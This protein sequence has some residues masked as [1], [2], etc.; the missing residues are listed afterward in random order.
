MGWNAG[1]PIPMGSS[2]SRKNSAQE[3]QASLWL[4][5]PSRTLGELA[6]QVLR[7]C[8]QRSRLARRHAA[9]LASAVLGGLGE[10]HDSGCV[11]DAESVALPIVAAGTDGPGPAKTSVAMAMARLVDEVAEHPDV[12]ASF[13]A[14]AGRRSAP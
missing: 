5:P 7:D 6:H 4:R 10:V 14:F 11:G 12:A 1:E 9:E 2:G 8:A 3:F 13:V